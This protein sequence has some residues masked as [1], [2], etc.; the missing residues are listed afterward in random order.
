MVCKSHYEA[1]SRDAI[2]VQE[3]LYWP[4]GEKLLRVL[5]L[6]SPIDG[7]QR[8]ITCCL[9]T[10]HLDTIRVRGFVAL[11]YTWSDPYGG[12]Q[13]D[14]TPTYTT[15]R[16]CEI[17]CNGHPVNVTRNLLDFL[18]TAKAYGSFLHETRPIWIDA[19]CI[20]QEDLD[21]RASQVRIMTWIYSCAQE[22]FI[23]LGKPVD[24]LQQAKQLLWAL[25]KHDIRDLHEYQPKN[26]EVL[27]KTNVFLASSA[28][29]R[30]AW[31]ALGELFSR[32]WFGRNGF[33]KKLCSAARQRYILVTI[34]SNTSTSIISRSVMSTV[35]G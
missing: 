17:V 28:S 21:E 32:A 12:F 30:E 4:L 27:E 2:A 13:E 26:P 10:V 35:G 31:I 22:V 8:K 9:E 3:P 24:H 6:N 1:E 19:V 7:D 33:S 15:D 29:R 14:D 23:W 11:S 16:D 18:R 25:K 5:R 20:N 34:S